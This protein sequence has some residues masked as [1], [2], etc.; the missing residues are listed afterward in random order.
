M[1]LI[2]NTDYNDY[3]NIVIPLIT[4][5]MEKFKNNCGN[6]KYFTLYENLLE[7]P[8]EIKYDH[9]LY[10][11]DNIW[12]FVDTEIKYKSLKKMEISLCPIIFSK[13]KYFQYEIISHEISHLLQFFLAWDMK[14]DYHWKNIHKKIGGT[15]LRQI[16][17]ELTKLFKEDKI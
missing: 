3:N 11:Y 9:S 1:I 14:H 8:V 2:I 17:P 12:A 16:S 5:A 6:E 15:G 7:I 10:E 4:I 13:Q